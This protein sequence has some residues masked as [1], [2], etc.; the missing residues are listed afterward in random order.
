[1]QNVSVTAHAVMPLTAYTQ[2]TP[3]HRPTASVTQT[4]SAF[5]YVATINGN[6]SK[7]IQTNR[8]ENDALKRIL[9]CGMNTC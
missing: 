7:K 2:T 4:T 9:V 6:I 5:M 1:M 3:E 8:L